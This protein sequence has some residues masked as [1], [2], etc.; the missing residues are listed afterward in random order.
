MRLTDHEG[1]WGWCEARGTRTADPAGE[2][3]SWTPCPATSSPPTSCGRGAGAVQLAVAGHTSGGWRAPGGL[4]C[5][6]GSGRGWRIHCVACS[7]DLPC[8][9]SVRRERRP[10]CRWSASDSAAHSRDSEAKRSSARP[11]AQDQSGCAQG[12]AC[13]ILAG[14]QVWIMMMSGPSMGLMVKLVTSGGVA[15]TVSRH[16]VFSVVTVS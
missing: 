11:R 9:A 15:P 3:P 16:C 8:G 12:G 1:P 4:A 2:G 14:A 10:S 7:P 6:G 13:V 5:G